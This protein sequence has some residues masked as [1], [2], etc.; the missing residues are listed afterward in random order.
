MCGEETGRE[1][2]NTGEE[3]GDKQCMSKERVVSEG[4]EQGCEFEEG[5]AYA[6]VGECVCRWK[7]CIQIY[8]GE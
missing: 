6:Y 8:V 2:V 1:C 5:R 3:V 4:C 7:G